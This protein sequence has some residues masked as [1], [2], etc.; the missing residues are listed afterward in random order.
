MERTW[1]E[2]SDVREAAAPPGQATISGPTFVLSINPVPMRAI[3]LPTVLLLGPALAAQTTHMISTVGNSFSPSL[4][5]AVVGDEIHLMIAAPHT[6]TE[7]DQA[8]WDANGSTSNGGYDY[9]AG[10]HTFTLTEAGTIHY[11]CVPHA[12]MGMKGR[13]VVTDATGVTERIATD[14]LMLSPNPANEQVR[15]VGKAPGGTTRV[16]LHD[17][18][19]MLI[20]QTMLAADGSFDVS[21]VPVGNYVCVV[22]GPNGQLVLR[23]PL[24]IQH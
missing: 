17:T 14:G 20:L 23:T 19:G 6:F 11:V 3:L 1:G 4:V 22:H 12:S 2:D 8:T 16:Q 13:I 10:E 24:A 5:N 7:V 9:N 15:L 18:K 21:A